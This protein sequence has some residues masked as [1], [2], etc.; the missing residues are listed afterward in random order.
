[1]HV[2]QTA[3]CSMCEQANDEFAETRSKCDYNVQPGPFLHKVL[4]AKA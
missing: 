4:T 3:Q 1:M 2:W